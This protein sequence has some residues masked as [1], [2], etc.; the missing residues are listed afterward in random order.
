MTGERRREAARE[1]MRARWADPE[2]AAR[3][4]A[5]LERGRRRGAGDP[6]PPPA[7]PPPPPPA[8]DPADPPPRRGLARSLL[9]GTPADLV[10][11][12]RGR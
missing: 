11:R 1:L 7:D 8:G 5:N 3:M 2:A 4:R 12:L 10:D 6:P 9:E